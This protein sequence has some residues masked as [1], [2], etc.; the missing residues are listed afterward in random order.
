VCVPACVAAGNW[1]HDGTAAGLLGPFFKD[2]NNS[3]NEIGNQDSRSAS[4]VFHGT[5]TPNHQFVAQTP[6]V[7][8]RAKKIQQMQVKQIGES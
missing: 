6:S 2:P 1:G 5:E 8:K 7:F 3:G 4:P